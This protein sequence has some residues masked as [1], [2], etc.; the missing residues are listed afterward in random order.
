MRLFAALELPE[1]A[2]AGIADAFS[3]LRTLAP[4]VKW[5]S[6]ESMHLT[7]HFFGEVAEAE[8]GA[9]SPVFEDAGLRVPA[10]RFQL[11]PAGF[12][13]PG[14]APKVLWVGIARGVE[15]M[16]AFWD[17]FTEKLQA[18]RSGNGP[19]RQWSPDS[20]GFSP[21]ITVARAGTAPLSRE[22][23]AQVTVPAAEHRV[24]RCVLFQSILGPG[25]ARYVPLKAIP[26]SGVTV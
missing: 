21:H 15:E 26:F 4:R 1:A 25:G 10:I 18:L 13:P 2:R 19:L 12:F 17:R 3:R 7:L 23:A 22:W 11:G 5:V 6:P 8:V 9:F 14:G 20:R 16:R 24:E